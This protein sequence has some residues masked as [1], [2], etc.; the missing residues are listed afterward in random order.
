[1]KYLILLLFLAVSLYAEDNQNVNEVNS[2]KQD[3]QNYENLGGRHIKPKEITTE[4]LNLTDNLNISSDKKIYLNDAKNS[5]ISA[6]SSNNMYIVVGGTRMLQID[7]ANVYFTF[8]SIV[9]PSTKKLHLD[10]GIGNTYI[11]EVSGDNLAL[12]AGGQTMLQADSSSIYTHDI[13]PNGDNTYGLGATGGRWT[14]VWAV[15]GTIQTSVS[16]NKKNII[17]LSSST[18]RVPMGATFK[19][20][21]KHKVKIKGKNQ[22]KEFDTPNM[23]GFIADSLPEEAFA[24]IFDTTTQTYIRSKEDVYTSAVI[25][26]LCTKVKELENRLK[27]LEK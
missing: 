3:L 13:R 1:M 8:G 12:V 7:P 4:K 11:S 19:R 26:I 24:V 22:T 21:E 27:K 25:G 15:N 6:D 2:I 5:Y 10:G 23:I 17:E 14:S 16:K 20:T 18:V 9:I